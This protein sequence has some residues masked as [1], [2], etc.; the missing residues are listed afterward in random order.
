VAE[1]QAGGRTVASVGHVPAGARL[2]LSPSL[3]DQLCQA[4]PPSAR[5]RT[6]SLAFCTDLDGCSLQTL[7]RRLDGCAQSVL[8]VRDASGALFGA[9]LSEAWRPG[10][11]YFGTGESFLFSARRPAD[12]EPRLVPFRWTRANAHFAHADAHGL[13]FGSPDSGLALDAALEAGSSCAS[14]TYGNEPLA[15]SPDFRCVKLEV[16]ALGR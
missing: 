4:V 5:L 13:S 1:W 11:R 9:Y 2:L 15:G 6:W 8:L 16:W 7:F 10:H 14:R 12:P 3:L